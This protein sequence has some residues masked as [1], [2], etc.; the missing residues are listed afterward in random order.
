[1][2]HSEKYAAME[3][4][5]ELKERLYYDIIDYFDKGKVKLL[6]HCLAW[7]RQRLRV[8]MRFQKTCLE[9]FAERGY[10]FI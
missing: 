2:L 1:M 7:D 6:F 8:G 5:R 10:S 4:H 9:F 3:T